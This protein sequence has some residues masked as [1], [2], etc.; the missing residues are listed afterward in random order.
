MSSV[1][2]VRP[3]PIAHTGSYATTVAAAVAPSGSEPASWLETTST[4]RWSVAP[5]S[6]PTTSGRSAGHAHDRDTSDG[7]IPWKSAPV[8]I[9]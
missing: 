2:G 9:T 3:V 5:A 7:K 1:V 4:A 8:G 6:M